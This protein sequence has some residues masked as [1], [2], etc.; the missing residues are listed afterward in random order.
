MHPLGLAPLTQDW[1]KIRSGSDLIGVLV[2]GEGGWG[3]VRWG[4]VG[5]AAV[6]QLHEYFN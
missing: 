6:L 2:S 5:A 3:G 4:E 1:L